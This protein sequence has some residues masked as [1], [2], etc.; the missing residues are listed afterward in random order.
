MKI[1]TN[2]R[3]T[4]KHVPALVCLLIGGNGISNPALAASYPVERISVDQN[5]HQLDTFWGI[6][7]IEPVAMVSSDSRY[8]AFSTKSALLDSVGDQPENQIYLRNRETGETTLVSVG[9]DGAPANGGCNLSDISSDGRFIVFSS[10]A[11]NL[12]NVTINQAPSSDHGTWNVYLYD[13][14]SGQIELISVSA[15]GETGGSFVSRNGKVSDDGQSVVFES[16]ASNLDYLGPDENAPTDYRLGYSQ[17]YL[18]ERDSGQNILLSGNPV[19]GGYGVAD[20]RMPD[21]SADGSRIV[22]SS[23]VDFD[24]EFDDKDWD[25]YLAV[26]PDERIRLSTQEADLYESLYG[27][28]ST[29]Y[30]IAGAMISSDGST[31]AYH[32]SPRDGQIN[33]THIISQDIDSREIRWASVNG[34]QG[35]IPQSAELRGLSGDGTRT[36]FVTDAE[37]YDVNFAGYQH[38]YVYDSDDTRT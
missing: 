33:Y 10:F 4:L 9:R 38:L 16:L 11:T 17:V 21:I 34:T 28:V 19:S 18:R 27:A 26:S 32:I 23:R 14:E 35:P 36:V 15:D 7:E 22:F 1:I 12:G 24:D 5:G 25:V 31:I 13:R 2:P 30:D 29:H 3:N 20:S 6:S 37:F 8:L